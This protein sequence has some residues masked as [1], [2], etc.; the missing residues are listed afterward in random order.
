MFTAKGMTFLSEEWED[1]SGGL[2]LVERDSG[3]IIDDTTIDWVS[4][5]R[6]DESSRVPVNLIL[7]F[8]QF[9]QCCKFYSLIVNGRI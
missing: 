8:K 9:G 1:N 6:T 4:S 7:H 3:I 5:G 2:Y